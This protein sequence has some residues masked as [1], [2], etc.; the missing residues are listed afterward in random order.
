[1]LIQ[2]A[3]RGYKMRKKSYTRKDVA[4]RASF[5]LNMSNEQT[6]LL[7]DCFFE[8]LHEMLIEQTDLVHIE[9]RNFGVFDVFPTKSRQNAR[10]PKTKEKVVIPPRRKVL[11]KPSKKIKNELYKSKKFNQ[12]TSHRL[13]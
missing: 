12:N 5:K 9:I 11:F 3:Q 13:R 8:I 1:M 4:Q 6:K 10:N 2:L 7:M